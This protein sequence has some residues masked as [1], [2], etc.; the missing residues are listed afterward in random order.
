MATAANSFRGGH[1]TPQLNQSVIDRQE[2]EKDERL[3]ARQHAHDSHTSAPRK[4][5][6]SELDDLLAG[7]D[8][9]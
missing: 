9:L 5:D 4:T 2:R 1:A 8:G 3:A 7:L 6:N